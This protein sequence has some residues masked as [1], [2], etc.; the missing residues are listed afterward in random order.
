MP[1]HHSQKVISEN[2]DFCTFEYFMHPAFALEME[3]LKYGD[4]VQV[5]EPLSLVT[6]IK[7]RI[8]DAAQLYE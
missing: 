1:I 2:S 8:A 5:L 4:S 6:E 7:K 3:I